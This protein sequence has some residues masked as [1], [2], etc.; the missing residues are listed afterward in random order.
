MDDYDSEAEDD[1][2]DDESSR[3]ARMAINEG[4]DDEE[5]ADARFHAKLSK[6]LMR[7]IDQVESAMRAE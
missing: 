7:Q 6:A 2:Y 3:E 1:S 4:E 5:E